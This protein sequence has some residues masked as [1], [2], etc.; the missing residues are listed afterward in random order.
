[1]KRIVDHNVVVKNISF[2]LRAVK[3]WFSGRVRFREK[4]DGLALLRR[5]TLRA[6]SSLTVS[7]RKI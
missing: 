1:M 3:H 2:T 6:A 4:H 7:H 5:L